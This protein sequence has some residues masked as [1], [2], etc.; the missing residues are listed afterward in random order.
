MEKDTPVIPYPTI[1]GPNNHL[2]G[3]D[4]PFPGIDQNGVSYYSG[5][6][7][8]NC[9]ATSFTGTQEQWLLG[10]LTTDPVPEYNEDTN[11][12]ESCD[13]A[14]DNQIVTTCENC[15]E[16]AWTKYKVTV[17][18]AT[19]DAAAWNGQWVVT[20][21]GFCGWFAAGP[22]GGWGILFEFSSYL[23]PPTKEIFLLF[24]GGAIDATYFS[25]GFDNCTDGPW[26]V[27]FEAGNPDF[28]ATVTVEK[29]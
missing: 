13:C 1:F 5:Q 10:A 3:M 15:P 16:G 23:D 6:N 4:L 26:E 29:F 9:P 18:G 11:C 17:A 24:E 7:V 8:V 2:A 12:P 20:Y 22:E 25:G 27:A 21:E 19:G 14:G 28:P